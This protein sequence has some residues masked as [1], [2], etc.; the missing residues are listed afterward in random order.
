MC[1]SLTRETEK[2]WCLGFL[3]EGR[4][5]RV[6]ELCETVCGF[7]KTGGRVLCVHGSGSFHAI[8]A[9]RSMTHPASTQRESLHTYEDIVGVHRGWRLPRKRS[10]SPE[11]TAPRRKAQR[12]Q[13]LTSN[14]FTPQSSL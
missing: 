14:S 7:A 10:V 1:G 8:L 9:S 13:L 3:K 12:P 6:R 11:R 2:L 5:T 4:G